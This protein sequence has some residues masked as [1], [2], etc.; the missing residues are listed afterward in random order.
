MADM[1]EIRQSIEATRAQLREQEA[2]LRTAEDEQ[3]QAEQ[4]GAVDVL[5]QEVGDMET[6]HRDLIMRCRTAQDDAERLTTETDEV[7]MEV[8]TCDNATKNAAW[9]LQQLGLT[10]RLRSRS[11]ANST[12]C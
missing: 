10:G 3:K 1:Q 9:T 4:R 7:A 5:E 2:A 6:K 12:L 8:Q 11:V